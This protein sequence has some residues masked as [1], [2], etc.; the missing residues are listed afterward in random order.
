MGPSRR[1]LIA[2][3]STV[4]AMSVFAVPALLLL[5]DGSAAP[6]A[7]QT[8]TS[9]SEL[10]AETAGVVMLDGVAFGRGDWSSPTLEARGVVCA[11]SPVEE[12]SLTERAPNSSTVQRDL[13]AVDALSGIDQEV[14][15][16]LAQCLPSDP[17]R[18][19]GMP[20]ASSRDCFDATA[21]DVVRAVGLVE[22]WSVVRAVLRAWP[23]LSVFCHPTGHAAGQVAFNEMGVDIVDAML[24]V[25]NDCISGALHGL[26]DAFGESNPPISAFSGPVEA[27]V[28]LNNGV[29]ADGVGHAAW[30]A[31]N[32]YAAAAEV[33][34]LFD[35]ASFRFTCDGG[36]FMRQFEGDELPM[37]I[38]EAPDLAGHE[39]WQQM[40]VS[41]CDVWAKQ[42]GRDRPELAGLGCWSTS[43]YLL[44]FPLAV[45][46]RDL[47]GDLSKIVELDARLAEIAAA[48]AAFGPEGEA[49]CRSNDGDNIAPLVGYDMD[50]SVALCGRLPDKAR[51]FDEC[52]RDAAALI[53]TLSGAR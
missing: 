41:L 42:N 13:S 19:N 16:C 30:S 39:A 32:D 21:V 15:H 53:E 1:R 12:T 48:C 36:V 17:Q 27:C 6:D 11:P 38:P 8:T 40:V 51:W 20:L 5:S 22:T 37:S 29:C 25:G 33:C 43:P 26:L 2:A 52:V 49:A 35:D 18:W 14:Y 28:E 47:E 23:E 4:A 46:L 50:G 44:W 10:A 3:V 9:G 34:G 7:P 45:A 24:G 31:Y